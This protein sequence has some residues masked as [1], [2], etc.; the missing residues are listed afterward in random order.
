M[1]TSCRLNI[2]AFYPDAVGHGVRTDEH[3]QKDYVLLQDIRSETIGL[4]YI[5]Q[6]RYPWVIIFKVFGKYR[7][8]PAKLCKVFGKYTDHLGKSTAS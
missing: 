6:T 4:R 5:V 2:V 1:W 7:G 3:T 8:H